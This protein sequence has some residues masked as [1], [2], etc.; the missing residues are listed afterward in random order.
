[1]LLG[2]AVRAAAGQQ[3]HL[4]PQLPIAALERP[5]T[6]RDGIASTN[7]EVTTQ[8]AD[9]QR[10]YDQGLT[11]LHH[12]AWIEAARSFNQ[13]ARLDPDLAPAYVGLSLAYGQ[14]G[15]GTMA[16]AALDRAIRLG[17]R[18]SAHERMHIQIR[19]LQV[20]AEAAPGNAAA[21]A[22]YRAALDDGLARFPRDVELWLARGVAE[23]GNAADR[24]QGV[25][26]AS[27]PFF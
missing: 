17:P 2:V 23:S 10:F 13:A 9:A 14:I 11:Y 1:M 20:A 22:A 24:G 16:Q 21:L 19:Q 7:D 12:F 18:S 5:V 26:A 6:L 27:I 4:M 15:S 25:R 8:S 3:A